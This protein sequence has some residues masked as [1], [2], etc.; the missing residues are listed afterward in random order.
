MLNNAE[1]KNNRVVIILD[2]IDRM[3]LHTVRYAKTISRDITVFSMVSD[4]DA[5]ETLRTEWNKLKTGFP[6]VVRDTS[7]GGIVESL[8]AFITSPEYGAANDE[9]T[10]I[11]PRLFVSKLWQKLLYNRGSK[12]IEHQ[13]A[14]Y[15][16][17][18]VVVL[19]YNQNCKKKWISI[20]SPA[21]LQGNFVS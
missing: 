18:V 17:F 3:T 14:K 16:N 19:Y 2:E 1:K 21:M 4:K 13:L 5:G 10:V 15:E 12:Y 11:I 9:I 20:C 7:C 6:F 8:T